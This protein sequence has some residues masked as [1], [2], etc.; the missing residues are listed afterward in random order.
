MLATARLRSIEAAVLRSPLVRPGFSALGLRAA[1][2]A[3]A[4]AFGP[5][6]F[7][8]ATGWVGSFAGSETGDTIQDAAGLQSS[9]AAAAGTSGVTAGGCGAASGAGGRGGGARV[10]GGRALGSGTV[11]GRFESS[12]VAQLPGRCPVRRRAVETRWATVVRLLDEH[13]T[14]W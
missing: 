3:V 6:A 4:A 9:T 12:A 1:A 8:A 14:T 11:R 13:A 2:F 10:L 7:A 5:S